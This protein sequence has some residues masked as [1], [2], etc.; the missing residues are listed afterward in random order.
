[1]TTMPRRRRISRLEL[2]ATPLLLAASLL[3]HAQEVEVKTN[4]GPA[5]IR[6]PGFAIHLD[7]DLFGGAGDDSDY[8]W[9]ATLTVGSPEPGRLT[10]PLERARQNIASLLS[11][12]DAAAVSRATQ[13]GIIAMTPDDLK[14]ALAVPDDRPY[15]SLVFLTSSELRIDTNG[16]RS[17]FTSLTVGVLGTG[18][19]EALQHGIHHVQGGIV[20]N[21]WSHQISEGGEPTARFVHAE[22]RL[23]GDTASRASGLR[24]TKLTLTASAGYLTEA[25]AALSI[26]WGRIAT[27]WWS[28]NPELGDYYPAPVAPFNG[29]SFGGSPEIYGFVGARV[30][31]HAYNALL[32]G[33]FRHSDVRVASEDLERFQ[34]EAWAGVTSA[35]SEWSLCYSVHVASHEISRAPADRTL[36]WATIAFARTF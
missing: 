23:L 5:T 11:D 21:G 20:P 12:S 8:S 32:Q 19:A 15:A 36:V 3:A 7:N 25:S 31:A 16:D 35:F 28:F 29:Y 34:V 17:R 9:G 13:F 33:Q 24:Q 2:L 26:R 30:K 1:L 22:Q 10:E 27:P 6:E 14:S 18:V 4:F